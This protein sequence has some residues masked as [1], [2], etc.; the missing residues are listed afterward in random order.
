MSKYYSGL[1]AKGISPSKQL[2]FD[3]LVLKRYSDTD[4]PW[5]LFKD[6]LVLYTWIDEEPQKLLTLNF[7]VS[8]GK[9]FAK[10]I[11]LASLPKAEQE[12]WKKF[13]IDIM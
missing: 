8:K 6:N 13:Q 3:I 10:L 2:S 11:E 12:H 1:L 9:V 4:G 5:K 7:I